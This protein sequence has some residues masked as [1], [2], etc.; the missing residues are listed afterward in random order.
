M[1]DVQGLN[2]TNFF[3]LMVAQVLHDDVAN[4][5]TVGIPFDAIHNSVRTVG[6][7]ITVKKTVACIFAVFYPDS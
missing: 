2:N 5:A 3:N 1:S 7:K 4:L 6:K